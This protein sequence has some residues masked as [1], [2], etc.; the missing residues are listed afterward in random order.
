MSTFMKTT[1]AGLILVSGLAVSAAP[2]SASNS[3]PRQAIYN[4]TLGA[5]NML[6]IGVEYQ[7]GISGN[8]GEV[9][10]SQFSDGNVSGTYHREIAKTLQN[11]PAS[12]T[13]QGS[14]Y[15]IKARLHAENGTQD[16]EISLDSKKLQLT[17]GQISLPCKLIS[18]Y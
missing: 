12:V 15:Q 11:E 6:G 3:N 16:V 18:I 9:I 13:K 10:Y 2:S 5:N 1:L 17:L 7:V 14:K 8:T 4:C